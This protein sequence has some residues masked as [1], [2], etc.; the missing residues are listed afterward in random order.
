V[1]E[2]VSGK[3][4]N[5]YFHQYIFEPLGLTEISMIPTPKMKDR[6]AY[7]HQ[8]DST[9]RIRSR[10]HLLRRSLIVDN[11]TDVKSL[12]NSGGAG[13]FSTPQDY[14][15]MFPS[16]HVIT[17]SM[18]NVWAE[19]LTVLLNN[20][21]SPITGKQLLNKDTVEEM[22]S[23]QIGSLP[24]L[25]EKYM[26][27]AE[28]DLTNAATGLHPTVTGDRQGWGLTFLLSGGTTG[29]SL[30]TAQW[31]GLPNLFWWCDRENGVAGMICAQIL[32]FG[33]DQV[34]QLYQDVEAGVYKGLA[35]SA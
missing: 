3:P 35:G 14:C 16:V 19:I 32:P 33:D 2:R 21:T 10:N 13:C 28:P 24:P 31:S 11:E 22:F 34:F 17:S 27:N 9:G 7:M 8:R 30:R 20:G 5:E 15:R 1:I 25:R 4:L 29:R 6:L 18:A 12:F 26:A 23:D